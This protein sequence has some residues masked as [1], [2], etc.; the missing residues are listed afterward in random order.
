MISPSPMIVH[1]PDPAGPRHLPH[2]DALR[3][4]AA[5]L[6][7]VHHAHFECTPTG[8]VGEATAWM[9]EGHFLVTF[10]IILSGY[11]LTLPTLS[12]A[13]LREGFL[14]YIKRRAWR[15][16]PAYYAALIGSLLLIATVMGRPTGRHWDFALPVTLQSIVTHALM[17]HNYEL[18]DLFK[19]NHVFWSI[20]VEWQIYFAFPILL[21][22]AR[23]IGIWWTTAL[24]MSLG[25]TGY[26]L[27][28]GTPHLGLTPHYYGMF[29]LG[30]LAATLAH[31]PA[32]ESAAKDV[33]WWT[34]A[35]LSLLATFSLGR[36]NPYEIL[37]LAF[38]VACAAMLVALSIPGRARTRLERPRLVALGG[39]SYS[40]YLVHAPLQHLIVEQVFWRVGLRTSLEF[41]A[42]L[43]GGTPLIVAFAYAFHRVFE[44]P[45][46]PSKRP[47][48]V[49]APMGLNLGAVPEE[50]AV[51]S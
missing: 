46:L 9:R 15:L 45:F 22:L 8:T 43:F 32:W 30:M 19:I 11:C 34:L 51:R 49:P 2:L 14:A 48:S 29:A 16:L 4:L 37:D 47:R 6:V 28:N 38:G 40:L 21:P 3:G 39:F 42:L 41:P 27:L 12:T 10:F 7:V 1:S 44:R 24:A 33:S 26:Y 35:A 50:A 23:R 36:T 18:A 13:R 20:A 5:L 17:I 25:T 31:S